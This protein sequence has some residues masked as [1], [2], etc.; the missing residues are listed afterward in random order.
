MHAARCCPR[1]WLRTLGFLNGSIGLLV[2]SDL[3][4]D[5]GPW[6]KA[7][8]EVCLAMLESA[9]TRSEVVLEHQVP[10]RD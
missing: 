3:N 1:S 5:D 9:E 10:T 6:A 8:M 7:T 2:V 4:S